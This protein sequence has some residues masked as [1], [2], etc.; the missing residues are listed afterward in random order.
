[1]HEK[2]KNSIKIIIRNKGE[3]S[4][5]NTS[6]SQRRSQVVIKARV[7]IFHKIFLSG[8]Y[9]CL[10]EQWS[11]INGVPLAVLMSPSRIFFPLNETVL[12]GAHS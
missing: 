8:C 3:K 12:G 5:Q 1:M 7:I 6:M 4:E 10:H 9:E 2:N 11:V